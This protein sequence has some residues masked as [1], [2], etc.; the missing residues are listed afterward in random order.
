MQSFSPV[1]QFYEELY[2]Q[3]ELGMES[4]QRIYRSEMVLITRIFFW[5]N[6][7]WNTCCRIL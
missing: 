6:V 2:P 5:W 3:N 1:N 7:Y 4:A